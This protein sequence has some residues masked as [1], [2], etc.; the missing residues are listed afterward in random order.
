[1]GEDQ[2]T[3]PS[4]IRAYYGLWGDFDPDEVTS[5]IGLAPTQTWR[6]GDP[7]APGSSLVHGT[8]LW[9]FGTE[10]EIGFDLPRHVEHVLLG[11]SPF[12][13]E[14]SVLRGRLGLTASLNCV[15]WIGRPTP[16]FSFPQE[17]LDR[18]SAL[19]AGLDIDSYLA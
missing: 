16:T 10:E 8:D 6:R 7:R 11:V 2:E 14:L 18:I 1:M 4:R 13:T 15:V 19:G 3:R 5:R 9:A 17:T 12:V